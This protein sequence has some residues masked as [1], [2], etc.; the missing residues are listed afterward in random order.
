MPQVP[1]VVLAVAAHEAVGP[2]D[3]SQRA[4]EPAEEVVHRDSALEVDA[5][6]HLQY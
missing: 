4:A 5:L 1:G 3:H 6:V 2:P